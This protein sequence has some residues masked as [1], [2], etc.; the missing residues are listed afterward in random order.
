MKYWHLI[1]PL[2]GGLQS[3]RLLPQVLQQ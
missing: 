1:V 3:M 2:W